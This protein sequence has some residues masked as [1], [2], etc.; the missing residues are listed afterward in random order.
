[1]AKQSFGGDRTII[2]YLLNELPADDQSRFEEAYF[3]D[4]SLFEQVQAL[5]EEI[6]NDYVK[7]DLSGRERRRFESHYLASEQRRARIETARQLLDLSSLKARNISDK[8]IVSGFFSL[9]SHIRSFGEWRPFTVFGVA[10]AVLSLLAAGFVI[11]LLRLRGRLAEVSEDLV[12]IERQAGES[13]RRLV[14]ERDLLA[15]ERKQGS[16]LREKL[17]ILN[18]QLAR[19]EQD[20]ATLPPANDQIVSLALMLGGRDINNSARAVLSARASFVE[21][22]AELETQGAAPLR[23]YRAVVTTDDGSKEIW[24]QEGIKPQR[25]K[26]SQYVV[27]RAPSDSFKSSGSQDFMLTLR[28]LSADGKNYDE[29]EFYYF[30]VTTSRR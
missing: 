21:L 28:A 7:G 2:R 15:E 25:R 13:E 20:R 1:M 27:V 5:E 18:S 26:S 11:E 12:A 24:T 19:L 10:M 16:D 8:R 3:S 29:P 9:R 22:R 14:Q 30:Q 6:I 23:S 17:E 4:G